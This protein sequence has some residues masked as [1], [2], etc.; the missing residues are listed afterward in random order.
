M[1]S[2][3]YQAYKSKRH[4]RVLSSPTQ[5]LAA[6]GLPSPPASSHSNES[7][8]SPLDSHA[9]VAPAPSTSSATLP[10]RKAS[11]F[12]HISP[13]TRSDTL[14]SRTTS[15]PSSPLHRALPAATH[16]N[17]SE[18]Q[19][20]TRS[21]A[22]PFLSPS[23]SERAL[24][25]IPIQPVSSPSPTPS[26]TTSRTNNTA[27]LP[28]TSPGVPRS[29]R[30]PY[31][32]GFQPKGFS[33]YLT[34]KFLALRKTKRNGTDA[35]GSAQRVERNK[36]ERRLEKLIDLH[37]PLNPS[38]PDRSPNQRQASGNANHGLRRASSIFDL[39][40]Y[41]TLNL[42]DANDLWRSVVAGN[43]GDTGKLDKRAMEQRITPW[44]ADSA[45]SKCPLC[46][47]SFHP[48]TNR[49]HH[50]RLCGCIICSL[51]P[52][53]PQ[54]PVSCS[55]LFVVDPKTRMIEEV[56]EGV[57][58]GVRKRRNASI[59]T[60]DEID[61]DE[62]FL[63]G[64][65]LC[66]MCRPVLSREQ[67]K[68]ERLHSHFGKQMFIALEKEIEDALPQFQELLLALNQDGN[69]TKEA[70]AARKRLLEA[71]AQYD[72]LA[73][74]IKQLPCPNGPASSQ[75]RIQAAI[76]MRANLF[77]QKNMFPLQS[78]PGSS[79][80]KYKP[81]AGSV[82]KTDNGLIKEPDI[83]SDSELAQALQPL[84]EQEALLETFVE[85][86]MVQRKFEDVKTLK[87]NLHEIRKEI[88][89][90]LDGVDGNVKKGKDKS[91]R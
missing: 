45:V 78:L 12:R 17:Q 26:P 33:R 77:L 29:L 71:F 27:K 80:I 19:L 3:P 30:L 13:K 44:E 22:T 5:A 55:I 56:G 1:A 38:K 8:D 40:T 74:K 18:P 4:S 50:C 7:P 64:V 39:D 23:V 62:K 89:R 86:A 47:T 35:D 21:S 58:Y 2:I 54:R 87:A 83:D 24:P 61:K 52:K 42:R 69:P 51:P 28:L 11:K 9:P 49:K 32:P 16:P 79:Q 25:P 59:G 85:E 75:G 66:R 63:K 68:Q 36:L 84:L 67:Y 46:S 43:L 48:L 20:T 81:T 15:G 72:A 41:K 76:L 57:D 88:Q 6:P 90:M 91:R 53:N 37:F 82:L 60:A 31:T 65:R 70:S 10:L 73:K 14:H 34:D